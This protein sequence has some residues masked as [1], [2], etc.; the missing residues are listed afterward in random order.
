[1]PFHL[2]QELAD[3]SQIAPHTWSTVSSPPAIFS[4]G[5]WKSP[6]YG[7]ATASG[8]GLDLIKHV[9]WVILH[10]PKYQ[11]LQNIDKIVSIDALGSEATDNLVRQLQVYGT[12]NR[13]S[14][15]EL[16][17]LIIH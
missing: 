7:D 1:M 14:I 11:S 17:H 16:F 8:Q 6:S 3:M 2:R 9:V 12:W 4:F 13:L 10:Q 5:A 15:D